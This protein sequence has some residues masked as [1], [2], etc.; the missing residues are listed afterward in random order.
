MC[1]CK[2]PGGGSNIAF[3]N[4]NPRSDGVFGAFILGLG[5]SRNLELQSE[6]SPM[7]VSECIVKFGEKN[8]WAEDSGS[9]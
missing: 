4:R 5:N 1:V 9:I 7:T 6:L 2:N 3:D 8:A